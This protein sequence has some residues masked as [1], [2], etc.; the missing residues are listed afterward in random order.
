MR[1]VVV[2][3]GETGVELA[4]NLGRKEDN[5][6]VL[7]DQDEN[8]CE[9]LSSDFDALVIHGDGSDPEILLMQVNSNKF[10]GNQRAYSHVDCLQHYVPLGETIT[11]FWLEPRNQK[12]RIWNEHRGINHMM[13]ATSLMPE[14]YLELQ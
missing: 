9:T 14:G 6:L 11:G 7:I 1:I 3:M 10:T 2:G 12:S 8:R 13:L 5:E 4:N